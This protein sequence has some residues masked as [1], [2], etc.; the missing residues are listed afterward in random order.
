M[1]PIVLTVAGTSYAKACRILAIIWEGSTTANDTAVLNDPVTGA[2]IWPV[3]TSSTST[4]LGIT[5]AGAGF[6]AP[7]GVTLSQISA[8]RVCVYLAKA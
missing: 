8:G 3:R 6:D 4:Y 7:N 2:V 5:F 1:N